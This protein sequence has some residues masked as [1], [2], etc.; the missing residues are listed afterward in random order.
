DDRGSQLR[1][2]PRRAGAHRPGRQLP[3]GRRGRDDRR[4][5]LP[6]QRHR[7]RPG[8]VWRP[9]PGPASATGADPA[10]GGGGVSMKTAPFACQAP[11]SVDEVVALLA[12][13]ADEAKVLAGG[14]SLVP[15]LA[16]RLAR[17]S[18]LIDIN[19]VD[20]LTGIRPLDGDGVVLGALTRERE[21]ERASLVMER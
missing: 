19:N 8:A 3:W 11:R 21:A 7:G 20:G 17:P 10:A 16:M 12:E 5:G 4:P 18:Q 1:D 13:H 9:G 2:L 14:Q 15:L 6:D